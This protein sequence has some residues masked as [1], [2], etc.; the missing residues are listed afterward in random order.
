M[1]VLLWVR[2]DCFKAKGGDM[3]QVENTFMELKKLGV[4][5]VISD[6]N[7]VDLK[8]FDIVHLFQLDWTP[9]T[10]LHAR[11][12]YKLGKKIVLSPIHHNVSEVKKFDDE[13]VFGLRRISKYLFVDQFQRD[14]FKN[15]YR[16][17]LDRTKALP[18]L[19]SIFFGLKNMNRQVIDWSD[20]VLTQTKLEA[21]DLSKSYDIDFKWE[22][23]PNG[24]GELFLEKKKHNN[25]FSFENYILSVGRIEPRK[26]NLTIISAVKLL[27]KELN[28]DFKLVFV[29][30]TSSKHFEYTKLFFNE[31]KDN[32]WVHYN[33]YLS[34]EQIPS[35]Y[36]YAKVCVS[37]SWFE[38]TGLTLLEALFMGANAVSTSPRAKEIL[39]DYC[40]YCSPEDIESIKEA[41][42][43]EYFKPKPK[44]PQTFKNEYTWENTAKK[45]LKIY[46]DLM[47]KESNKEKNA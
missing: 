4:E 6:K 20:Y 33:N 34:Y 28:K 41:I 1:K 9:E 11:K 47:V 5:V 31:L 32:R 30:K 23:I 37:A 8:E 7:N 17:I 22:V 26:N 36:K 42:K 29:G 35:I 15:I 38:T 10:Y 25:L 24:V 2:S 46:N 13:Y 14:T 21:Y 39:G 19:Y 12:A 43:I 16:S 45:T 44:L 40:S 18:T 3:I 27:R